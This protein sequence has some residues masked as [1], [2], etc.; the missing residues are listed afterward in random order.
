MLRKIKDMYIISSSSK[1]ELISK[2]NRAISLGFQ[3]HGGCSIVSGSFTQ[4]VILYEKSVKSDSPTPTFAQD[5]IDYLNKKTA[6]TFKLSS[7]TKALISARN[8]EGYTKDDFTRVIDG[9]C[10]KWLSD[11]KMSE[12]LRPETLFSNKFESYLNSAPQNRRVFSV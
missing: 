8:N 6:R 9:R 2:L 7:K 12:Y 10:E 3:L 1:I 11:P 4:S 5:I